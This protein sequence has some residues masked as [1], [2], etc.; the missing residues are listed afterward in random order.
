MLETIKGKKKRKYLS[1]K[2]MEVHSKLLNCNTPK[3]EMYKR[4][5]EEMYNEKRKF[6]ISVHMIGL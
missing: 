1:K 2:K 3:G 6:W 4:C 5:Q